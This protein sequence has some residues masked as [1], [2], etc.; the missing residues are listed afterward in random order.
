[1]RTLSSCSP[2]SIIP[3]T[4]M[5]LALRKAIGA[6]GSC[7]AAQMWNLFCMICTL[8]KERYTPACGRCGA[9]L[10]GGIFALL[11]ETLQ[12]RRIIILDTSIDLHGSDL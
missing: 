2:W 12:A 7:A 11:S 3:M 10:K 9:K 1:M 8:Q 4:P 5:G 6:T